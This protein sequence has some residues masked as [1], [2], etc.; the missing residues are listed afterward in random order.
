MEFAAFLPYLKLGS[1]KYN[2]V[3]LLLRGK[4]IHIS[5]FG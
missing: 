5:D 1:T 4:L 2:C 3:Y